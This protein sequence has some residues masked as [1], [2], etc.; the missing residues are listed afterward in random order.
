MAEV[1]SQNV[2]AYADYDHTSV[3]NDGQVIEHSESA[4][5]QA[6]AQE[7]I[8]QHHEALR[9]RW[10]EKCARESV[11]KWA[12]PIHDCNM[13]REP[14][15]TKEEI[16]DHL[17]AAHSQYVEMCMA[18]GAPEATYTARPVTVTPKPT[19]E[20][21]MG[22]RAAQVIAAHRQ[23]ADGMI[24]IR[25]QAQRYAID[26][27]TPDRVMALRDSD[28]MDRMRDLNDADLREV[29]H[30]AHYRGRRAL[31]KA[32]SR[33]L[34]NRGLSTAVG[35]VEVRTPAIAT[36]ALQASAARRG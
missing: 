14:R 18:T 29:Y 27:A 4:A 26:T 15:D 10:A 35:V 32:A 2:S 3:P 21:V 31:E 19:V 24:P 13:H 12:C 17:L 7:T 20:D 1:K 6:G 23:I 11:T 9:V 25:E 34:A 33:I 5:L 30:K 36:P 28:A 8:Y 22:P 16:E